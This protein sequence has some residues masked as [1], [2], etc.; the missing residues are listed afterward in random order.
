MLT[1]EGWEW[2]ADWVAGEVANGGFIIVADLEGHSGAAPVRSA[3]VEKQENGAYRLTATA[4]FAEADS[5]FTWNK[6]KIK[7]ADGTEI[8]AEEEDLGR[9]AEGAEWEIAV[10]IDFGA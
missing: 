9:K 1:P 6:R 4:V 7:L 3:T 10:K 5:N 2:I 8:E